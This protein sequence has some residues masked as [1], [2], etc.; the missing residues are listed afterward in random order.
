MKT[1]SKTFA[2]LAVATTLAMAGAAQAQPAA[3]AAP[4][5][6]AAP[7]SADRTNP[8]PAPTSAN[9]TA[10][11]APPAPAAAAA[12]AGRP[13]TFQGAIE[14]SLGHSHEVAIARETVAG[15]E[16][17]TAGIAARRLPGLHVEA[18]ANLFREAYELPFGAETFTLHERATTATAVTISQPLTRLAYLSELVGA[19][20]HEEA[21]SRSDYDRARLDTAYRTAEAYL[22][23]LEAR[24][25]AEVAHRSV[26]DLQGELDRAITFR[27]A[28]V[29]TDI[30]VL[31]FRSAKAAA[32]QAAL[33][34]DTAVALAEAAL[35]TLTGLPEGSTLGVSDDLPVAPPPL[36]F[37]LEEAQRRALATRP[38]LAA[39]KQQI[40]AADQA[41]RA[42]RTD[43]LPDLRAVATWEHLTGTQPFQPEN[44]EY[45]GLR[46][47]WNV[48]DWGATHRA[49]VEAEHKKSRAQLT[50]EA[51]ADQVR[52][53]VRRKWL[54]AHTLFESLG[55]ATAQQQTADEAYR[56]Q[57]VRFDNAAATATDVLDA[58]TESARA[59]LGLAVARYD[60]YLALVGLAR[61]VGDL[62]AAPR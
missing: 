39:A 44:T 19:A 46:L 56:L 32:D 57:K 4:A 52:L 8:A 42:A 16:A 60:Y 28:E 27:Q 62:P 30:D 33:R 43:Y 45:V 38:E 14:M 51:L 21:A 59:R 49:V 50:A 58:E 35:V 29:S 36:A 24:A 9:R 23:A 12:A 17:H 7:A 6:P 55:A 53:E 10:P 18:A 15:A 1:S 48:W 5:A 20:R 13:L 47:S 31:R 41:R 61:A 3:A 11:A 34:A 26:T 22:R 25:S 54:E 40:A 2:S 37:T